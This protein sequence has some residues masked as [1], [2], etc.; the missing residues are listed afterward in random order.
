MSFGALEPLV[1]RKLG[2]VVPVSREVLADGFLLGPALRDAFDLR[3]RQ[4]PP[5]PPELTVEPPSRS[6]REDAAVRVA[7]EL[8]ELGRITPLEL[9]LLLDGMGGGSCC[10]HGEDCA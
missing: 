3:P 2:G 9:A 10:E 7:R 8:A 1:V 5:A 6:H 4:G